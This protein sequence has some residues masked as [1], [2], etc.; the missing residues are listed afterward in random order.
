M[1]EARLRAE[2]EESKSEIQRLEESLSGGPPTVHKDLSSVSLI[3]KWSGLDSGVPIE[4]FLTSIEGAAYIGMWE[5]SDQI[6]IAVLKLSNAAGL[7]H[8]GCPEL[9]EKNVTWQ[10]FN[11]AFSQRFKDTHTDPLNFMRL[12][13]ARQKKNESP[14]QFAGRCLRYLRKS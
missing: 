8:N 5:E 11:N 2:L 14:Q 7:F 10:M 12:Q 4:E 6:R 13:T 1:A 3:P 9:L